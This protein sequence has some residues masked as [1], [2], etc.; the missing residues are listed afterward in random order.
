MNSS[1]DSTILIEAGSIPKRSEGVKVFGRRKTDQV[2]A[3][4]WEFIS[5][6]L[7][8]SIRGAVYNEDTEHNYTSGVMKLYV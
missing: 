2:V 4:T 5:F 8:K 3:S 1:V 6:L 7:S